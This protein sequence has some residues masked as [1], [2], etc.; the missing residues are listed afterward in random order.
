MMRHCSSS[1]ITVSSV[2]VVFEACACG[3]LDLFAFFFFGI[4]V[5]EDHA[6]LVPLDWPFLF[7]IWTDKV[8]VF[9]YFIRAIYISLWSRLKF[10]AS[11]PNLKLARL[12]MRFIFASTNE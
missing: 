9:T 5:T 4:V 7:L 12:G 8:I 3:G 10:I 2:A 11:K 6:E 1:E